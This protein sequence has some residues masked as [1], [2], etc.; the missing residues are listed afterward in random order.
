MLA[1]LRVW[2]VPALVAAWSFAGC[3]DAAAPPRP[4]G[5]LA[6]TTGASAVAAPAPP[7]G[8]PPVV[9]TA[10]G[11]RFD[12]AAVRLVLDDPRLAAV[13]EAADREAW[14]KAAVEM[15]LAV[16]GRPGAAGPSAAEAPAWTYELGRLRGLAGDAAGA[17]RAFDDAAAAD[18]ALAGYARWQSAHWLVKA[19]QFD[20]AIERARRVPAGLAIAT[21]VELTLADALAGRDQGEDFDAAAAIWRGYLK[22]AKGSAWV[23]VALRLARGLL[24]RP[25]EDHAEEAVTLA[26]RVL[27]EAPGGQ[28]AGDAKTMETDALATLSFARRKRFES[29][30][31]DELLARA[32]GLLASAQNRE[33]V[34]VTDGLVG[35]IEA[36]GAAPGGERACEGWLLRAEALAKARKKPEAADAYGNAI[37]RC[38]GLPRRVDALFAGGRASV[39]AGRAAEAALRYGLLEKEFPAHSYADDSRLKGARA[40]LEL[41]DEAR[42]TAMLLRMPDDYPSGDMVNDGLFELALARI[43]KRDWAGAIAPLERALAR[44]PRERSYAAAGRLPYFLGRARLATG[45]RDKAIEHFKAVIDGHPLSF[46][47]SLAYSRLTEIDPALAK[48]TLDE[49]AAREPEGAFDLAESDAFKEPAFLRAVELVR[50]GEVRQATAELDQLGLAARTAPPEVLWAAAFLLARGGGVTQSHSLFRGA[51]AGRS[52]STELAEWLEHYPRGRWRAAWELAYPRPFADVVAREC[53]RSGISEAFAYAIMREESAFDPRVVSWANAFG[54]M[55]LIVPTAK[56]MAKPL[57]LPA[58]PESLKRPAVN[59]ALGCRY[60]SVLRRQFGDNPLLAIP[61]YNAGGGAPKKWILAR[62]SE[63]FDVFVERIP[64]EETRMYTKRVLTSLA[65]YEFLYAADQPSEA[66]RMPLAAS[67][68][69]RVAS[70]GGGTGDAGASGSVAAVDDEARDP[71]P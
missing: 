60:L 59:V 51:L 56:T 29:A 3:T 44:V 40:V 49:A 19:G 30:T 27:F 35:L 52:A 37:N 36:P 67:P 45:S 61:G 1:R 64:Y 21:D 70:A 63:D 57:G 46:Y 16:S 14:G 43:E 39:Q 38:A 55:Q 47:M 42:F 5:E 53:K 18:W 10:A 34:R 6:P 24:A 26:R 9:V 20:A 48:K 31:P 62:P 28:G 2:S 8:P 4:S 50:Q 58:D 54:L 7:P 23:P 69:S 32:R 15:T 22:R 12:P 33:A 66:M 65:A 25:S 17:A 13:R 41:G 71:R 11:A 68:A